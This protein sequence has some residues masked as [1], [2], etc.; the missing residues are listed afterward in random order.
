M[1]ALS[2]A[3]SV[4]AESGLQPAQGSPTLMSVSQ[5]LQ[6]MLRCATT[7]THPTHP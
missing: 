2:I 4:R 1:A 7:K 3:V 5:A 6:S